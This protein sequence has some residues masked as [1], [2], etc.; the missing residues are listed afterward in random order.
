VEDFDSSVV[1]ITVTEPVTI[2]TTGVVQVVD[3]VIVVL[4][5]L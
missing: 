2:V 1:D 3:V 5:E 4:V